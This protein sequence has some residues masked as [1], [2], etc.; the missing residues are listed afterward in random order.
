[1]EDRRKD[2][3]KH[4]YNRGGNE[5]HYFLALLGSRPELNISLLTSRPEK[6]GYEVISLNTTNKIETVGRIAK[7]SSDPEEVIPSADMIII[8]VPSNTYPGYLNKIA[9]YV[10]PG[11]ILGFIPGTGGVEFLAKPF[12][13]RGCP[14]FGS[15]RVPSGT[16]VIEPGHKV[17]SLGSRK[18]FRIAAIPGSIT[19][20]VCAVIG[21]LLQINT[22]PL[23]HYLS[24]T[25]TPSNPILH[26][27]RLYGLFHN[28]TEGEEYNENLSFYKQWDNF[29]SEVLLGCN[30]ELQSCCIKLSQY[31]LSQ[32]S[33]LREHY[34]ICRV[35]G[36]TDIEKMTNKIRSLVYLKDLVP[37]LRIDSGKFIPNFESRYFTEDFPYGL[38]ILRSFCGICGTETPYM[39]TVLGWY[40]R[41]FTKNYYFNGKFCGKG[42][43]ELPLPQ[44]YN[45]SSLEDIYMYY[46]KLE[47]LF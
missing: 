22:V 38:S 27:S 7:V 14:V 11:T 23:P 42:L 35:P 25:F 33:S 29:S 20:D 47:A 3:W 12:I 6:F 31:N 19:K 46:D 15:Q 4:L 45:I 16:K 39:D 37:M 40:D 18:D 10:Q 24:V 30:D 2:Y 5:G 36:N 41:M 17:E 43:D 44:N 21:G 28:Y 32:V 8:L 34:E 13:E 1:M 9:P 26:T